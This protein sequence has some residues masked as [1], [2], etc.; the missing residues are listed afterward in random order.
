MALR[1][2]SSES[3]FLGPRGT[4]LPNRKGRRYYACLG[5]KGAEGHNFTALSSFSSYDKQILYH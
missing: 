4:A 2:N 1:S 3:T 5:T